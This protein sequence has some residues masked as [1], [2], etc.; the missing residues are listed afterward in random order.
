MLMY[1]KINLKKKNKRSAPNGSDRD[2]YDSY[3]ELLF[4]YKNIQ[5]IF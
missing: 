5:S 4:V 2:K 3:K 1:I